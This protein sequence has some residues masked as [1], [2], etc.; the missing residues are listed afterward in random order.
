MSDQVHHYPR[1]RPT[2]DRWDLGDGI[3][4]TTS[5]VVVGRGSAMCASLSCIRNTHGRGPMYMM[6]ALIL[7]ML[8]AGHEVSTVVS[9]LRILL[10]GE[11]SR[12]ISPTDRQLDKRT[13][14]CVF[15][16]RAPSCESA[17][18]CEA[19][20]GNKHWVRPSCKSAFPLNLLSTPAPCTE[21]QHIYI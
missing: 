6:V 10:R 12:L 9:W 14:S 11:I 18:R 16:C 4:N 3:N 20:S 5:A 17:C 15:A 19:F 7:S 13:P 8:A 2:A 21:N 1:C